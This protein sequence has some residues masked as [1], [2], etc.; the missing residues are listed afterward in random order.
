MSNVTA[1]EI[2]IEL[3]QPRRLE[4]KKNKPGLRNWVVAAVTEQTDLGASPVQMM[5]LR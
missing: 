2:A 1:A 5:C 4:K 3:R